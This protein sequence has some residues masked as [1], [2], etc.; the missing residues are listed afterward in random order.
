MPV[1]D[2]EMNTIGLKANRFTA[3]GPSE[4]DVSVAARAGQ[5]DLGNDHAQSCAAR[6][7]RHAAVASAGPSTL[8]FLAASEGDNLTP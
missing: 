2:E 5:K 4:R 8:T 7:L 1:I 6:D 3:S